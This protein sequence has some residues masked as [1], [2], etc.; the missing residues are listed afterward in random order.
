[1]IVDES[2]VHLQIWDTGG[3]ERFQSL[4]SSFYRGSD[5][6]I[7]VFDTTNKSSFTALP[8]WHEFISKHHVSKYKPKYQ[9]DSKPEHGLHFVV[10]GNKIDL[11]DQRDVQMKDIELFL[12][13][14]EIS[15]YHEVSA[16][17]NINIQNSL[18]GIIIKAKEWNESMGNLISRGLIIE[19]DA[20]VNLAKE[21]KM[22]EEEKNNNEYQKKNLAC[23]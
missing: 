22:D 19:D 5:I 17:E 13:E 8:K 14:K 16:K 11:V 7:L 12:K 2:L 20:V 10:L 21:I 9:T 6:C 1:M 18:N 3:Q 23:C 4:A 15:Y